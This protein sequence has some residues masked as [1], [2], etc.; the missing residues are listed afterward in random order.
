VSEITIKDWPYY[1]T[2][3]CDIEQQCVLPD[4]FIDLF[5][6]TKDQYQHQLRTLAIALLRTHK[7]MNDD[8][9]QSFCSCPICKLAREVMERDK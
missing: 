3:L 2:S 7:E 5:S 9:I 4:N 8:P 1:K 6:W